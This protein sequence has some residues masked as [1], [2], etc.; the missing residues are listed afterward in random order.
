[1]DQNHRILKLT[2]TSRRIRHEVRR[3]VALIKL[4]PLDILQS[5][6]VRVPAL[7]LN[8]TISADLVDRFR[9]QF[10]DIRVVI[11]RDGRDLLQIRLALAWSRERVNRFAR[12][13]CSLVDATLDM[14]R[15]RTSSNNLQALAKDRLSKHRR[16]SRAVARFISSTLRDL[17][18]HLRAHR[19]KL[20][21]KLDL[22]R[23]RNAVLGH[24]RTAVRLLNHDMPTRRPHRALDRIGQ[25]IN[26]LLHLKKRLVIKHD[27]FIAHCSTFQSASHSR[28]CVHFTYEKT[29][30]SSDSRRIRCSTPSI[31]TSVPA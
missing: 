17:M 9:D 5:R 22:L 18:Q 19:F 3:K 6:F 8:N 31:S 26:A 23:Y 15:I 11:R 7:D 2:L 20:R 4:H 27:L 12:R 29:P 13:L 28:R 16:T 10:T 24:M 25:L 14:H 21:W 1:M 30:K